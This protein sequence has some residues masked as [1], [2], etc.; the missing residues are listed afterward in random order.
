LSHNYSQRIAR[1]PPPLP[2]PPIMPPQHADEYMYPPDGL[3]YP[4]HGEV[5]GPL[6]DLD[7]HGLSQVES[8]A[9]TNKGKDKRPLPGM[10][11]DV[12]DEFDAQK[13]GPTAKK[14]KL[15]ADAFEHGE[16]YAMDIDQSISTK[17]KGKGKQLAP[18]EQSVD[19]VSSTPKAP[20]KKLG[21]RKKAGELESNPPS[22]AGDTTPL[23]SRP[24]SP[25]PVN[26]SVI[27]ELEEVVPSLK[28]AKKMDDAAML[29]RVKTLEEAQRKVWTNIA[30]RD[31][32]KV[33]I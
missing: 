12:G 11:T 15:Q 2:S 5:D 7:E 10:M 1:I 21:A 18:R 4:P 26:T 6:D 9:R 20:R 14:R 33:S 19:T 25:A 16:D 8:R 27:F 32:A 17:V 23:P 3:E 22:V 13:G 31:V 24:T 30:R 29:K 28:K